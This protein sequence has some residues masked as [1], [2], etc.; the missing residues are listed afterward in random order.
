MGVNTGSLWGV[1]PASC[2]LPVESHMTTNE[3]VV[4]FGSQCTRSVPSSGE[5]RPVAGTRPASGVANHTASLIVQLS[6]KESD[7]QQPE[8]S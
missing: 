1:H 6:T 5:R 3:I 4:F 8:I 7:T 2:L